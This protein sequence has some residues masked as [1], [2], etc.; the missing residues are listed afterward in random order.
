M[1]GGPGYGFDGAGLAT[2][3]GSEGGSSTSDVAQASQV[4]MGVCTGTDA[5]ARR[6]R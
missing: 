5:T 4:D 3:F 2:C 1:P 6:K